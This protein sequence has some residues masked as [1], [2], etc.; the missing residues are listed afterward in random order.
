MTRTLSWLLLSVAAC[1]CSTGAGAAV[2]F[3]TD[4][5]DRALPG[6]RQHRYRCPRVQPEAH[7]AIGAA[8]GHRQPRRRG[9]YAWNGNRRQVAQRRLYA[10][11]RRPGIAGDRAGFQ[12]Q[13]RLQPTEGPCTHQPRDIRVDRCHRQSQVSGQYVRGVPRACAGT[14]RQADLRFLRNRR[15]R[16]SRLRNAPFDD[17]HRCH[18]CAVQGRRAG[19]ERTA[20]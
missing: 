20:R 4:Q 15:A 17:R 8:R 3:A 13:C 11:G 10:G 16:T 6:R 9:G 14:A 5:A 7:R 19:S 1:V 18:S 12:S 2:S